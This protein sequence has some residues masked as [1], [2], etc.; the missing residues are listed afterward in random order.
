MPSIWKI[1]IKIYVGLLPFRHTTVTQISTALEYSKQVLQWKF[2]TSACII[3]A[4]YSEGYETNK[5]TINTVF[6]VTI[7]TQQWVS[8]LSRQVT[9]PVS[10]DGEF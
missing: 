1:G 5:N 4:W 2:N 10:N 3:L 6:K 8:P 7:G 9:Y